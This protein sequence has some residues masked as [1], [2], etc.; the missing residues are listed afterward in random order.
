MTYNRAW[1]LIIP[2]ALAL[3]AGVLWLDV[4]NEPA[5]F[6]FGVGG[7]ALFALAWYAFGRRACDSPVMSWATVI[8]IALSSMLLCSASPSMMFVQCIAFPLTW[9]SV[10]TLREGIIGN[11]VVGLS[12]GAGY[13][14]GLGATPEALP[15][16]LIASALSV[17]LS[18]V[19]GIWITRITDESEDRKTLLEDLENTQ[20]ELAAAHRDSGVQEERSRLAREIHDTLAQ[21]LTGIVMLAQNARREMSAGNIE[22]AT[23]HMTS[24]EESARSALGEARALVAA[25]AGGLDDGLPTA[26]HR[27]AE[28][29][30]RETGIDTCFTADDSPALDKAQQVVL[31]RCAQ[32]SLANIRKH[33]QARAATLTLRGN[34]LTIADDGVG[35]DTGKE[36]D[37]FGLVGMRDR[38]ALMG[39]VLTVDSGSAGT[40]ITAAL[41]GAA[42]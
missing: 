18:M 30:T 6:T 27:L 10:A 35:F 31:L 29:F 3:L 17:S 26:L 8:T 12:V 1:G 25:S 9:M 14:I 7:L 11:T 16:A 38:L 5:R 37:G 41:Q 19:L 42:R 4:G 13:Y 28:G 21:D 23:S 24:V 22:L 39:G 32:E 20:D 36:P 15:G 2:F 40:T 34:E 33:A